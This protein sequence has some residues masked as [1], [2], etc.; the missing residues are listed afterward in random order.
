MISGGGGAL[1]WS[2]ERASFKDAEE[3][4]KRHEEKE[5]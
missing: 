4:L 1:L 3:Y 5:T 2:Q